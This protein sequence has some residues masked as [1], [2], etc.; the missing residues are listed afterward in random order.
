MFSSPTLVI[1]DVGPIL[2]HETI[3]EIPED[4][5][6]ISPLPTRTGRMERETTEPAHQA[7]PGVRP[8]LHG[9]RA[10]GVSVGSAEQVRPVV[11][12]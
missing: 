11:R 5:L 2:A 3:I 8:A 4:V 12:G 9:L 1:S 10:H 7:W 6:I